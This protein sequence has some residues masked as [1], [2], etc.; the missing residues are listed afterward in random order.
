MPTV[1]GSLLF[2]FFFL[3][4]ALHYS[5]EEVIC[6]TTHDIKYISSL[7]YKPYRDLCFSENAVTTGVTCKYTLAQSSRQTLS[8]SSVRH[9]LLCISSYCFVEVFGFISK[10]IIVSVL[11]INNN[12][13]NIRTSKCQE[14]PGG[15]LLKLLESPQ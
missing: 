4:N 3:I 2:F 9:F 6:Y 11:W 12:S 10:R 15:R 7:L 8:T 14:I 13:V 5:L 1:L